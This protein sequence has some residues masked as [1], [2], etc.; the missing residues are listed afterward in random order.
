MIE[1]E[2]LMEIVGFCFGFGVGLSLGKCQLLVE[3]MQINR[4]KSSVKSSVDP[5]NLWTLKV[6]G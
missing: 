6:A 1:T 3:K 4:I 5:V 2:M